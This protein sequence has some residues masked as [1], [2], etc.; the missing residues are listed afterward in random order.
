[1]SM[2]LATIAKDLRVVLKTVT[3]NMSPWQSLKLQDCHLKPES[4][5]Y[6]LLTVMAVSCVFCPRHLL[7]QTSPKEGAMKPT[8][9]T[10][11]NKAYAAQ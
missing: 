9:T 4:G 5:F 3:G 7:Q 11:H 10:W 1:M 8:K 2:S 6:S